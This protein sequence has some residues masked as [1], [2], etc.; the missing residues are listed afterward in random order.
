MA[1]IT[2]AESEIIEPILNESH[3]KETYFKNILQKQIDAKEKEKS[4]RDLLNQELNKIRTVLNKKDSQISDL[5][6]ELEK[7]NLI[8]TNC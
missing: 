4:T 2:T 7:L 8:F 3:K 1:I 5:S 6:K